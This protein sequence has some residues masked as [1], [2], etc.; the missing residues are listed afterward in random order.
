MFVGGQQVEVMVLGLDPGGGVVGVGE[1]REEAVVVFLRDGIELV[2]VAAGAV[3][4]EA[5][6]AAAHLFDQLEE[7]FVAFDREIGDVLFGDVEDGA[8][9]AGGGEE[10]VDL[11]GAGFGAAPVD[12]FVAGELLDQETVPGFVFVEGFDDVIAVAPHAFGVLGLFGVEVLAGG[13]DVAGGVEPLAAPAFAVAR[14]GEELVDQLFVVPPCFAKRSQIFGR[15]GEAGEVE[16][17]AADELFGGGVGAEGE[18]FGFEGSEEKLIDGGADPGF[19]P[20]LGEGG[21]GGLLEGPKAALGGGEGGILFAGEGAFGLVGGDEF[22]E[23]AAVDP[24]ADAVDFGVG[25]G[26]AGAFGRHVVAGDAADE[27]AAGGV[28]FDDDGA[29]GAALEDVGHGVE[30]EAGGGGA[31]PVAAGA[32]GEED[33]GEGGGGFGGGKGGGAGFDPLLDSVKF[34]VGDL[35]SVDG[36]R[37]LARGDF[38]PEEAVGGFAL[39]DDGAVVA[40]AEGAGGGAEVEAELGGALAVAGEAVLGEDGE[41]VLFV[42]GGGGEGEGGG[43]QEE[44]EEFHARR[45]RTGWAPVTETSEGVSRRPPL[46]YCTLAWSRPSWRRTVAIMAGTETRLTTAL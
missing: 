4:G 36:G 43:E 34:G 15:G 5:E 2:G 30:A 6:G 7:R 41:D 9:V 10:F 11:R 42:V 26:G 25:E 40:A 21:G 8:E 22:A 38:G 14:G 31:F 1:E 28:A 18:A 27:E 46:G 44:G 3:H 45:S 32:A 23:V 35:L 20:D 12:E 16:V 39:G 17:G 37:H 24:F 33:G 29:V 13:V 19:G